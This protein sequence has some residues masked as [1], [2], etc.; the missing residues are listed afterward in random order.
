M[1]ILIVCWCLVVCSAAHAGKFE[2]GNDVLE[3]CR[4][5]ASL[6]YSTTIAEALWTGKCTGV[7]ETLVGIGA[8]LSEPVRFCVPGEVTFNKQQRFS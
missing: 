4:R 3:G 1:R 6:S 5:A 8:H 7:I 2:D